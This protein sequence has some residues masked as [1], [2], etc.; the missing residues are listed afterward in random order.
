M[1]KISPLHYLIVRFLYNVSLMFRFYS[2]TVEDNL[3]LL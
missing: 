3:Y 2:L 1:S